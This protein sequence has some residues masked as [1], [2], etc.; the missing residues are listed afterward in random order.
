MSNKLYFLISA[1]IGIVT[2]FVTIY[3]IFQH[4][5][6]SIFLWVGVGLIVIYLSKSRKV[7]IWGAAIYSFITISSWLLTG[8]KGT[9]DKLPQLFLIIL[10]ASTLCALAGALGAYLFYLLFRRSSDK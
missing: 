1:L 7:G 3:S 5:W 8:F 9:P 4:S 2:G 10:I 6:T